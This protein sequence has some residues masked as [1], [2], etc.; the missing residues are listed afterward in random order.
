MWLEVG[1]TNNDPFV[2]G[3]YYLDCIRQFLEE[4]QKL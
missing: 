4:F 1:P 2:I 3:Q